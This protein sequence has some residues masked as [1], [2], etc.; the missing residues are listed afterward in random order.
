[1]PF[2]LE[3]HILSM[4]DCSDLNRALFWSELGCDRWGKLQDLVHSHSTSEMEKEK[5]KTTM[6][7]RIMKII[8]LDNA[9]KCHYF[10]WCPQPK[11]MSLGFERQT[12]QTCPRFIAMVSRA[13]ITICTHAIGQNEDLSLIRKRQMKV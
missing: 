11:A 6:M 5:N 8:T 9:A 12:G 13:N 2:K 7:I 1:M 10:T 3:Q 4:H